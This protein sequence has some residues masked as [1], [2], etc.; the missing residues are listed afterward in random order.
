MNGEIVVGKLG[1]PLM[2]SGIQFGHGQDI[3][4]RGIVRVHSKSITIQVLFG[5]FW[6]KSTLIVEILAYGLG[7]KIHSCKEL[8]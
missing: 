5:S 3:G 4:P 8:N 2:S 1:D 7:N 6:W